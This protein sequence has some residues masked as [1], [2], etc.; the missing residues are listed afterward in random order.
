MAST[1]AEK[2]TSRKYYATHK[3]YREDKIDKQIKKQ[4]NNKSKTNEYHREY[5]AENGDYRAYKQ[6]YAKAY[7]KKEPI[8]SKARKDR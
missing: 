1:T 6:K 2:K 5:Y 8:K 3:K 4:K 7:R